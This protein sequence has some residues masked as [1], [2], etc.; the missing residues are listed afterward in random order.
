MK[1]KLLNE[2]LVI[3]WDMF[4]S[5]TNVGGEASCQQDQKTFLIMRTSQLLSWNEAMLISYLED[6]KNAKRDGINLMSEK[7][8]H[9]MKYTFPSEYKQIENKLPPK[10]DEIVL[11]AE[12]I[13]VMMVQWAKDLKNK[14]PNIVGAGRPIEST[15]DT[16]QVTSIETYSKGELLTYG[17]KTLKLSLEY[18]TK[19]LAEGIN[20]YEEVLTNTVKMYGFNSI[21]QADMSFQKH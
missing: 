2:I 15:G 17:I 6:L 18:Y 16:Q 13:T 19:C 8:G 10:S 4:K 5:V 21:A 7:Y 1:E 14:Y 20:N 12:I 3:E 11:L 9:M